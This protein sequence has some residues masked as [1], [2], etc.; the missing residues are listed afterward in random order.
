MTLL[1][2]MPHVAFTH[3]LCVAEVQNAWYIHAGGN[4]F[5]HRTLYSRIHCSPFDS[6][7]FSYYS[8]TRVTFRPQSCRIAWISGTTEP[9]SEEKGRCEG[10]LE[11]YQPIACSIWAFVSSCVRDVKNSIDVSWN[12][13]N[14][15][16]GWWLVYA[17]VGNDAQVARG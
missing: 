16:E 5:S 9:E 14:G 12:R 10:I 8:P 6:L 7:Y 13:A 3:M 17:L 4:F 2:G 15:E 1:Y 11:C